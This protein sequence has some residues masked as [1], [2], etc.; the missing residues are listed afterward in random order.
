M[1]QETERTEE[2]Q[3]QGGERGQ[4]QRDK[5]GGPDGGA[6]DKKERPDGEQERGGKERDKEEGGIE[7]GQDG[8][9]RT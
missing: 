9:L 3:N 8:T 1:T 5:E 4:Q 7:G 6:P 2:L